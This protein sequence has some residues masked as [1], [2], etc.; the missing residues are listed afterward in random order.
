MNNASHII[1]PMNNGCLK[2]VNC[3]FRILADQRPI[4]DYAPCT[5]EEYFA[6]SNAATNR[7]WVAEEVLSWVG[8]DDVSSWLSV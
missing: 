8:I 4:M 3:A 2:L 7:S 1:Q 6:A 5:L